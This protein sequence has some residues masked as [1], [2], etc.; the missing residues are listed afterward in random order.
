MTACPDPVVPELNLDTKVDGIIYKIERLAV[1]DG[2]GIRTVIFIKGCPLACLWCSSPES[3]KMQPEIGFYKDKCVACKTCMD[4]CPEGAVQIENDSSIVFDNVACNGCGSCSHTCLQGA[5]KTIGK[6][7]SVDDVIRELEK[8]AIFYHR[9]EGG[10]TLSGGEPALQPIFSANILKSAVEMGFHTAME[11][12]AHVKWESL[13][14]ILRHLDLIYV[15][16]KH[17]DR[18]AHKKLTG[19]P[20]DLIL[21]NIRQLTAAFPGLDLI[22][23][24]PLI[25]GINDSKKNIIETATFAKGLQTLKRVELLPYH[26]YGV[27]TYPVVGKVYQLNKLE[28][29]TQAHVDTLKKTIAHQGIIAQI[30]G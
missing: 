19:Q 4:T 20:N 30:G 6:K 24:I 21:E 25:P 1:Y 11:T 23:R 26:R 22:L 17:M 7:V 12:C 18:V 28:S 5:R 16:I 8:D 9:S 15:D 27:S 10:V 13:E 29:L 3:Q 14:M 2:P